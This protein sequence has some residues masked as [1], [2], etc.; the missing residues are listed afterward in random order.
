MRFVWPV[1]GNAGNAELFHTT[2]EF[3]ETFGM[4]W[5][6]GRVSG[7]ATTTK[8]RMA[9]AVAVAASESLHSGRR[10]MV[11][12]V[13]GR[14]DDGS[15]Y[16]PTTVRRYLQ[17]IGVPLRVWSLTGGSADPEWGEVENVSAPAF[18]RDATDRLRRELDRQR[19]AWLPVTPMEAL[20]VETAPDCAW[21]P[22][23]AVGVRER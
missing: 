20:R 7:P 9:D 10:R 3:K 16:R 21:E 22:L 5:L 23:S 6:L 12:L 4:R 13:L 14:E 15:R 18:L 17:R 2:G 11:L 1:A 19:V 8:L